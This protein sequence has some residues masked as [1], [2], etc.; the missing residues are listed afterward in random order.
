MLTEA[1]TIDILMPI[2]SW[3]SWLLDAI[4]EA[5]L[6][7]WLAMCNEHEGSANWVVIARCS[8]CRAATE[9]PGSP[10]GVV[11]GFV[12]AHGSFWMPVA[13]S[14]KLVQSKM[15]PLG[16]TFPE[17]YLPMR[18]RIGHALAPRSTVWV[19][20]RASSAW[21]HDYQDFHV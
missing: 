2:D 13:R 5:E 21:V 20:R 17:Q 18:C 16:E 12:E 9:N 4:D 14:R 8:R 15:I 1:R 6:P 3:G 19:R 11:V 7:E 10:V